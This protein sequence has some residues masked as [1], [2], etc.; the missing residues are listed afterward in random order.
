[1][2]PN[3]VILFPY[4]IV[5]FITASCNKPNGRLDQSGLDERIVLINI[6]NSSRLEIANSIEKLIRCSPKVIAI[7]AT[8]EDLRDSNHDSALSRAIKK[9]KN[10]IVPFVDDGNSLIQS[11]EFFREGCLAEGIVE[12]WPSDEI[13]NA[14]EVSS[15]S[16]VK[17]GLIWT[18][19]FTIANYFD[20]DPSYLKETKPNQKYRINFSRS[21]LTSKGV[22]LDSISEI[23]CENLKDKI[24]VMGDINY[25][26]DQGFYVTSNRKIR[27]SSTLIFANILSTIL[28][29]DF[30]ELKE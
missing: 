24:V 17:Q 20:L 18:F 2:K 8:F 13:M 5:F 6:S 16:D 26:D 21:S 19:P 3:R 22:A 11:N 7:N 15:Y 10:I 27:V 30:E 28:S 4:I 25:N 23:S 14:F 9:S 12:M 1:M 29:H